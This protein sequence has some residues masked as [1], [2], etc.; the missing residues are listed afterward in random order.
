MDGR[1]I[2]SCTATAKDAMWPFIKVSALGPGGGK[3]GVV[4]PRSR[5]GGVFARIGVGGRKEGTGP[6]WTASALRFEF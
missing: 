1:R 6:W 2:P 3:M 5:E 4:G